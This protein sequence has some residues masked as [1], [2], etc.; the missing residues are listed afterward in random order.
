MEKQEFDEK[1]AIDVIR[2]MILHSQ[3]K[4]GKGADHFI[5]WGWCIVTAAVLT[6]MNF[7]LK[8]GIS[9]GFIWFP[10]I[11]LPLVIAILKGVKSPTKNQRRSFIE[12]SLSGIW[13]G[14]NGVWLVMVLL[15]FT[16]G[17]VMI[18]P[19][20]IAFFAW[21]TFTTG[22]ILKF[23]PLIIGGFSA[24]ILAIAAVFVTT[25]E[26]LLIMALAITIT[27]IIP[28]YMLKKQER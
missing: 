20:F 8:L 22:V 14:S 6:Y 10:A 28:G 25:A 1:Q 11:G 27:Y 12:Y 3:K 18:Y 26:I 16:Y 19:A 15:G 23:K 2:S 17:W 21:G 5:V 13:L 4:Y 7:L 24:F 9:P